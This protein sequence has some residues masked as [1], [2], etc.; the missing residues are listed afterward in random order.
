MRKSVDGFLEILKMVSV[1]W[2]LLLTFKFDDLY[3]VVK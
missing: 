1:F 3:V 2:N